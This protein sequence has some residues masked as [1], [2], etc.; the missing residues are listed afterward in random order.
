MTSPIVLLLLVGVCVLGCAGVSRG[1]CE[2]RSASGEN[3]SRTSACETLRQ[4]GFHEIMEQAR[5]AGLV[6]LQAVVDDRHD[7]GPLLAQ[8]AGPLNLSRSAYVLTEKAVETGVAGQAGTVIEAACESTVFQTLLP[9]VVLLWPRTLASDPPLPSEDRW[10][11]THCG[12]P[13]SA[14]PASLPDA[15]PASR[16]LRASTATATASAA[17]RHPNQTCED[18]VLD[19]LQAEKDAACN[20]IAGDSC[21]PSKVSPKRLARRSCSEIKL[22][23]AAMM[24]CLATRERIQ[25][26]CFGS[27]PDLVHA[28]AIE[29]VQNGVA[30]CL[31][32]QAVNCA[33]GHPM[34]DF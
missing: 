13:E 18:A 22:R 6:R 33:P 21:S 24:A 32:L 27:V 11:T 9:L 26:R 31:A 3:R 19:A 30:M 1:T 20:Q 7:G 2:T 14:P 5:R 34:A 25:Q 28:Q 8:S 4:L 15:V 10:T 12:E 29:S 16:P 23:I 17:R